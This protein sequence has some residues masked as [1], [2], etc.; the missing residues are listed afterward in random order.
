ML[1][2]S[3]TEQHTQSTASYSNRLTR[4]KLRSRLYMRLETKAGCP[5]K[6]TA[7]RDV[8]RTWHMCIATAPALVFKNPMAICLSPRV[9]PYFIDIFPSFRAPE[10]RGARQ[11]PAGRHEAVAQC[12]VAVATALVSCARG[13]GR[14]L[15]PRCLVICVFAVVIASLLYCALFSLFLF[16]VASRLLALRAS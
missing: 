10:A 2:G 12:A 11:G 15:G 13:P 16:L 5:C 4:A 7:H 8:D 9:L 14:I 3:G 6:D 1:G